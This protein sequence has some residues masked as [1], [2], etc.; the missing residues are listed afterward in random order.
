ML[1][2][3]AP[4]TF[5]NKVDGLPE[6]IVD[7]LLLNCMITGGVPTGGSAAELTVVTADLLTVPK[8]LVA[9]KV[10][11]VDVAGDN[12]LVPAALTCPIP[13][14]MLTDV[15]PV[16]FHNRVDVPPALIVDG[17]LL[18]SM[19]AGGVGSVIQP[20]MRNSN[21]SSD[22]AIRTNLF[23]VCASSNMLPVTSTRP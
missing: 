15:A 23:N 13:W 19:I 3:V 4:V 14:S 8:E 16:T 11:T 18:N 10:Y 21:N 9:V 7:G 22:R 20:G 5:Q 2:D 1:T 17:L 12:T 6:L